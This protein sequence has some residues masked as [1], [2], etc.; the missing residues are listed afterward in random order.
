MVKWKLFGRSKPKE[1]EPEGEEPM[2]EEPKETMQSDTEQ[3]PE[4][5]TLAEHHETLY[6]KRATPKKETINQTTW[7]DIN[8]IEENVDNLSRGRAKKPISGLDKK[9]D[10]ILSKRKKK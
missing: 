7:R 1:E 6:T 10:K 4:K 8:A 3:E 5:P 9:V 2:Q